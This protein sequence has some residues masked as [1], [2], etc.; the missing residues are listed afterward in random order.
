[1]KQYVSGQDKLSVAPGKNLIS[2][3]ISVSSPFFLFFWAFRNW[4]LSRRVPG[5]RGYVGTGDSAVSVDIN[6]KSSKAWLFNQA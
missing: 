1:M 4:H 2:G 5:I 6:C 3:K